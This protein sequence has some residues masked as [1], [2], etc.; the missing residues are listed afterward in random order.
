MLKKDWRHHSHEMIKFVYLFSKGHDIRYLRKKSKLTVLN[1]NLIFSNRSKKCLETW[2]TADQWQVMPGKFTWNNEICVFSSD[3]RLIYSDYRSKH[4][5]QKILHF[6][7]CTRP[8]SYLYT[9]STQNMTRAKLWN[10]C[11]A[12]QYLGTF[13]KPVPDEEKPS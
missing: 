9:L 6:W 7:I 11:I 5:L 10:T 1:M 8:T 13:I 4:N 2:H 12:S 3:I